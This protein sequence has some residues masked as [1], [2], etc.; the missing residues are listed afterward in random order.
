MASAAAT[1]AAWPSEAPSHVRSALIEKRAAGPCV[2][3]KCDRK[4]CGGASVSASFGAS[5][6]ASLEP[7]ATEDVEAAEAEPA[8][9]DARRNRRA[10]LGGLSGDPMMDPADRLWLW[11]WLRELALV[12]G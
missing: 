9:E 1:A 7:A 11:V 12:T 3:S 2:S 10:W 8:E 4:E 6:G 5:L